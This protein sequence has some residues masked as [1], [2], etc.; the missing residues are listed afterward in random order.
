MKP[1]EGGERTKKAIL[2][3]VGLVFSMLLIAT[4]A[5]ATETKQVSGS[6]HAGTLTRL[7]LKVSGANIFF[8][9]SNKGQYVD[10]GPIAGK[11]N[12]TGVITFHYEDPDIVKSLDLSKPMTWPQT[13]WSY[14][15]DRIVEG[16]VSGKSGTFEVKIVSS[17]FGRLGAPVTL[18]GTWVI[19]GGTGDL[20]GLHGQGSCSNAGGGL[21]SYEGQIHLD[22]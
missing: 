19:M 12:Q 9:F 16:T 6:W 8:T 17:G 14:K 13:H 11:F 1:L 7:D 22:P 4:P 18:D 15:I 20:S 10:G 5:F 2:V 3:L 21:N